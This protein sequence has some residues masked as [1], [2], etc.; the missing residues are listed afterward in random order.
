MVQPVDLTM[1]ARESRQTIELSTLDEDTTS[2]PPTADNP[3][4]STVAFLFTSLDSALYKST[5]A[6]L[7]FD[8]SASIAETETAIDVAGIA[9]PEPEFADD[10]ELG[11]ES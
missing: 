3:T 4:A 1:P 7:A 5:R 11:T 8:S 6:L 2:H 10:V 9:D